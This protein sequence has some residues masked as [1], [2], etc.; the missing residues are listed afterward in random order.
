MQKHCETRNKCVGYMSEWRI[1]VPKNDR[2]SILFKC[3]DDRLSAHGGVFKTADRVKRKYWWPKMEDEIRKYVRSCEVCKAT[4]PSN[5][6]QRSPMGKFKYTNVP[7]QII[8]IDFVGPLPR[9]KA[10]MCYLLVVVNA[11]S[12]FMHLHPMRA[13]NTNA[14]I[15]CLKELR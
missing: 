9:S 13:A 8:S 11:F 7:F 14:T 2:P 6:I 12:K 15:K 10:G 1:V 5:Q 3:H 4:K